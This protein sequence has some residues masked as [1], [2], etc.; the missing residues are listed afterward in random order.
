MEKF[1]IPRRRRKF[2]YDKEKKALLNFHSHN[3]FKLIMKRICWIDHLVS[4]YKSSLWYFNLN[5]L[6]NKLL[7]FIY[8][9]CNNN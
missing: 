9:S 5:A 1:I 8:V 2:I 7:H 3:I 4:L 6:V